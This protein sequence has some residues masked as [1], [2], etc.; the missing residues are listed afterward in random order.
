MQCHIT[1][2]A[3]AEKYS[4]RRIMQRTMKQTMQMKIDDLQMNIRASDSYR[5]ANKTYI[6]LEAICCVSVKTISIWEI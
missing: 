1:D 2:T 5:T 6:Q 4:H 3:E